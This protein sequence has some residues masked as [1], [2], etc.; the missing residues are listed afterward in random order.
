MDNKTRAHIQ[1]IE[2]LLKFKKK[3]GKKLKW[4]KDLNL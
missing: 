1:N 2:E 4:A 3:S